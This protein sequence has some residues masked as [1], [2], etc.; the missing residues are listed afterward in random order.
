MSA[1]I[2]PQADDSSGNKPRSRQRTYKPAPVLEVPDIEENASERKRILNVLAQRRYSQCYLCPAIDDLSHVGEKK[3]LRRQKERNKEEPQDNN[4]NDAVESSRGSN[5]GEH[6]AEVIPASDQCLPSGSLI[7]TDTPGSAGWMAC[8]FGSSSNTSMPLPLSFQDALHASNFASA[9]V[10]DESSADEGFLFNNATSLGE[11]HLTEL[12]PANLGPSPPWDNNNS[13]TS[14]SSSDGSF[15][16]SYL[17]P[18]HELTLLRAITRIAERIGCPQQIWSLDAVSPFTQGTATPTEQLPPAWKPTTSQ[19]LVPHHPLLDFLPWP[20]VRDRVISIF[21]MPEG[22]RPPHAAGPLA[23][24]NFAY[25]FEDNSEGVRVYGGDPYDA[26]C[27]EVGQV[28]FERWWFIFDRDVIE[29]S[30]RWRRLRGAP[31]LVLRGASS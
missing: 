7:E 6:D 10:T 18:V 5:D 9:A 14:P 8:M 3:R 30:N 31:P 20:Q 19:L 28:L 11:Q 12:L 27:W 24:V 29:N 16:D 23:L 13:S 21:S 25:D 15:A 1:N 17:L 22:M 26:S 2:S 4:D